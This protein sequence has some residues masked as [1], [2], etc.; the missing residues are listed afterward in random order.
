M[1]DLEGDGVKEFSKITVLLQ[2]SHLGPRL[3]P[4]SII[5]TSTTTAEWAK[6]QNT[7]PPSPSLNLVLPRSAVDIIYIIMFIETSQNMPLAS[8]V[9]VLTLLVLATAVP[10]ST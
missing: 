5:S 2:K 1:E 3:D 7:W 4:V 6:L 9:L 10:Q 8:N